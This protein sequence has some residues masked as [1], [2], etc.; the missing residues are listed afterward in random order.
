MTTDTPAFA[1]IPLHPHQPPPDNA[2]MHGSLDAVM[3]RIIDTNARNAA[4]DVLRD[5]QIEAD[6]LEQTRAQETQ[7]LAR[8]IR[9]LN[10]T[11]TRLSRRMDA[12]EAQQTTRMRHDA[13]R[14]AKRVQDYLKTL[15]DPDDPPAS[16]GHFNTGDL[17]PL[18]PT[19]T[20]DAAEGDFPET[21]L[22]ATP[23]ADEYDY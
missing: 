13:A 14:E 3:E 12:V 8:G 22:R 7:I 15:P 23:P 2:I 18:P 4:V 1:I 19:N 10:D 11:I 20:G 6:Q 9:S 5:A 16:H 21:L 17:S